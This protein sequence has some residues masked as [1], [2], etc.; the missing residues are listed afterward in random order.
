MQK[1]DELVLV[2]PA[3][4]LFAGNK[5]FQGFLPGKEDYFLR[6]IRLNQKF[7]LRYGTSPEQPI[8]VEEDRTFKQIIVWAVMKHQDNLFLYQ[9]QKGEVLDQYL[10]MG[11]GGH[12]RHADISLEDALRREL[13]EEVTY[14]SSNPDFIG[15]INDDTKAISQYHF[16]LVYLLELDKPS[17]MVKDYK[18][19]RWGKL[20]HLKGIGMRKKRLDNWSLIIYDYISEKIG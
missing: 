16:G 7:L 17:I 4:K 13:D 6:D 20:M 10:M 19:I 9:K 11:I 3:E 18:E 1:E 14:S 2:V 5:Y 8:P 12:V 15:Y